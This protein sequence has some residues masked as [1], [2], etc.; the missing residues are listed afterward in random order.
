MNIPAL[1]TSAYN[2]SSGRLDA[3]EF[4]R[5]YLPEEFAA[6]TREQETIIRA[7]LDPHG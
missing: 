5:R 3:L 4:V 7:L 2:Y 1:D 6:M